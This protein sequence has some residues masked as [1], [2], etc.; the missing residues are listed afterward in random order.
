ML[1]LK[2]QN[3]RLNEFTEIDRFALIPKKWRENFEFGEN[4]ISIN[5]S[6]FS[7]RTYEIPCTCVKEKHTHMILDLRD[8]WE[9]LKL[10]DHDTIDIER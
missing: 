2:V 7:I 6:R 1:K 4:N 10:K 8:V 5:G 3:K 9:K